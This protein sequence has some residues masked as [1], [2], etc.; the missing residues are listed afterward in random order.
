VPKSK[1]RSGTFSTPD[2]SSWIGHLRQIA[3][4]LVELSK[5]PTS[6][7]T[8]KFYVKSTDMI[9]FVDFSWR[10]CQRLPPG[11]WL[12]YDHIRFDR[13]PICGWLTL[14][15]PIVTKFRMLVKSF[16]KR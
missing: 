10:K 8:P 4:S 9:S 12:K 13:I 1:G 11:Y 3:H 5:K 16:Q 2:M 7:A 6:V 14:P 15:S